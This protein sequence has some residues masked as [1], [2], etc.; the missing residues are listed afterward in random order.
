[1]VI[2]TPDQLREHLAVAMRVELSTIP[3]YLY[4]MYSIEDQRS[5]AARLIM[6]IVAEEMLH[7]ALAA[8]L[9]AAVGGEPGFLDPGLQPAYPGLLAHHRPDLPLHLAPASVDLVRSTFMV[10]ERP[11]VAAAPPEADGYHTL[12]Q[13]YAAIETAVEELSAERPDRKSG[14]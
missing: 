10:L 9:L 4:A 7:L 12:G 11:G 13:F 3:P 8:N 2:R 1:M 6:S 14:V 5:E